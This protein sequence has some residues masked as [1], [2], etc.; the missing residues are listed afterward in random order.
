MCDCISLPI[1]RDLE[2][3][4]FRFEYNMKHK[5]RGLFVL[6]NNKKFDPVTEMGERTGTDVDAANL[7]MLFRK[8][9]FD[10]QTYK[11]RTCKQ[12]KDIVK[13]GELIVSSYLL[14][15]WIKI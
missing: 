3:E 9:G 6:I 13:E 14:I 2:E 12:M 5:K 7:D 1:R 8:L 11:D 4:D 15:A 10:V